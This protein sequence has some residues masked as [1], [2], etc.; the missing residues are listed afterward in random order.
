[1]P[2]ARGKVPFDFFMGHWC[3]SYLINAGPGGHVVKEAVVKGNS[4]NYLV[5]ISLKECQ[6]RPGLVNV[7]WFSINPILVDNCRI[8]GKNPSDL[9][10]LRQTSDCCVNFFCGEI[11]WCIINP[12]V[13][14]NCFIDVCGMNNKGN[15]KRLEDLLSSGRG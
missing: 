8:C 6:E 12:Y 9:A 10:V 5:C 14:G 2:F 13:F 3:K 4:G 11:L 1:M 15:S 7:L